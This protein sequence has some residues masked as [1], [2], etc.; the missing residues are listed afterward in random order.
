[1]KTWKEYIIKRETQ[2]TVYHCA[3]CYKEFLLDDL[4]GIQT[5]H[6]N[7]SQYCKQCALKKEAELKASEKPYAIKPNK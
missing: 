4:V 3:G 6:D 2:D 7:I 1:M 5:W